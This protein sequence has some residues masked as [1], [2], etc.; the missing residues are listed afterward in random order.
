V[1]EWPIEVPLG[2][3]Y[4]DKESEGNKTIPFIRSIFTRPINSSTRE[5]INLLSSWFDGELIYGGNSYKASQL[6]TYKGGKMK[7][8]NDMLCK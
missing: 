5:Q 6:R 2:D 1:E 8:D 7:L 3:P 4:F